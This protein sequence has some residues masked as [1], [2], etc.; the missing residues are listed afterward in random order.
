MD[1]N[2]SWNLEDDFIAHEGRGHNDNPPG[3]G[4]GRYPWGSGA[5]NGKTP[6]GDSKTKEKKYP[7]GKKIFGYQPKIT[8]HKMQKYMDLFI[9]QKDSMYKH[10]NSENKL[11]SSIWNTSIKNINFTSKFLK[12]KDID[13]YYSQVKD[14]KLK[15]IPDRETFKFLV[16]L[17]YADAAMVSSHYY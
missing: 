4:S 15:N 2:Y 11:V 3:R 7:I 13:L 14:M 6:L 9:K 10:A 17:M 5:K 1:N 12:D 8:K 16:A